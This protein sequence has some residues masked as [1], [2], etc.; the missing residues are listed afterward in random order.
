MFVAEAWISSEFVLDNPPVQALDVIG[1]N[2]AERNP[3]AL[4]G[5]SALVYNVLI[6]QALN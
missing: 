4:E 5:I 3:K 1:H 6:Q 2:T